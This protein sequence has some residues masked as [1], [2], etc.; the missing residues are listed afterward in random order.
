MKFGIFFLIG[1]WLI[2]ASALG[3]LSVDDVEKIRGIFKESE[4]RLRA[5]LVASEERLRA[6]I[7]LVRKE[8][9]ETETRL[10]A[11]IALVRAENAA[12]EARTSKQLDRNFILLAAQLGFTAVIIGIPLT[13]VALQMRKERDRDEQLNQQQQQ[14][15]EQQR[16]IETLQQQLEGINHELDTLKQQR[17]FK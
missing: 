15:H 4:E 1:L 17:I 11:E 2:S 8:N 9:A 5:E 14:I 10:H 13:L 12:S 3:E 7:A 6:E 16:V